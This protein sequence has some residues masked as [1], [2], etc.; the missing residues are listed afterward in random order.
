[1]V[2]LLRSTASLFTTQRLL[3][4]S[5]GLY[6]RRGTPL[7]T[8]TDFGIYALW[9][10]HGIYALWNLRTLESTH[11][12]ISMLHQWNFSTVQ[13]WIYSP[14]AFFQK[15]LSCRGVDSNPRPLDPGLKS[16]ILPL[17]YFRLHIFTPIF[18][19]RM[20]IEN[21]SSHFLFFFYGM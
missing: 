10:F 4:Y 8:G 21:I 9:N 6:L 19:T 3:F 5:T 15:N 13:L 12:G 17:S 20:F 18:S 14:N 2:F 7:Y 11:F 1:M 16:V